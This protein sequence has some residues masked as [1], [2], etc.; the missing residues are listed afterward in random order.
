MPRMSAREFEAGVDQLLQERDSDEQ[1]TASDVL[2]ATLG[3]LWCAEKYGPAEPGGEDNPT[4]KCQNW[5][6]GRPGLFKLLGKIRGELRGLGMP[7]G[8]DTDHVLVWWAKVA[9]KA[10]TAPDAGHPCGRPTPEQEAEARAEAGGHAAELAADRERRRRNAEEFAV[11]NPP[12]RRGADPDADAAAHEPPAAH[13]IQ[14]AKPAGEPPGD[15]S[16]SDTSPPQL[17]TV[18]TSPGKVLGADGK[19]VAESATSPATTPPTP[20]VTNFREDQWL[21]QVLTGEALSVLE[22]ETPTKGTP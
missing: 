11:A 7:F 3:A 19:D 10:R 18:V 12:R 4:W 21:D 9:L 6:Q 20:T 15:V 5:G 22:P 2:K 14:P 1:W 16:D 8:Q 17:T 13:R